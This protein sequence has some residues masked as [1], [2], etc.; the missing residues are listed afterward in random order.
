MKHFIFL[1]IASCVVM[2]VSCNNN[3]GQQPVAGQATPSNADV[4]QQAPVQDTL[5]QAAPQT[6]PQ[7]AAPQV[8]APDAIVKFINSNFSGAT[9]NGTER[10]HEDGEIDV[11]L[12]DGSKVEFT[13]NNEWKKIT[14]PGKGVPS[15][16]VPT[17]ITNYVK[18][19]YQSALIY[20][21]DKNYNTY[22]VQLNNGVELNFGSNGQFL[23]MDVDD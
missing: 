5:S 13:A 14:C 12:S 4:A 3:G 22:E 9:I 7:A 6:T 18:S 23:G 10:D 11:Y 17:A 8:A 1:V 19:N 16:L 15:A 2:F 20:K 21:I